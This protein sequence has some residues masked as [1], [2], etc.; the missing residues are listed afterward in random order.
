MHKLLIP[1][2]LLCSAPLWSQSP[3]SLKITGKSEIQVSPDEAIIFVY[4]EGT[5]AS[6]EKANSQ[7]EEKLQGLQKILD[8]LDYGAD[9]LKVGT[10]SV[11]AIRKYNEKKP[12]GYLA[13]YNGK[14]TFPANSLEVTKLLEQ[15]ASAAVDISTSVQFAVS[16]KLAEQ[17]KADLV[18]MAI[19]DARKQADLI[20]GHLEMRVEGVL[21]IQYGEQGASPR[22]FAGKMEA[23]LADNSGVDFELQKQ[24]LTESIYIEFILK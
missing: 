18:R 17:V 13:S 14:I 22:L 15:L 10:V 16:K 12:S 4:I 5:G 20:A 8:Q 7:A 21:E 19:D 1:V 23:S 6:T 9:V 24:T 3:T 2:L 11:R